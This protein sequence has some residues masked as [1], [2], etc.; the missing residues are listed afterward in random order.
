MHSTIRAE[1]CWC[2]GTLL[3]ALLLASLEVINALAPI[4]IT[5]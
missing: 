1:T 2:A 3:V 5:S 4:V